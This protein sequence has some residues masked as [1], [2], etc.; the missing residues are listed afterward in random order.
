LDIAISIKELSKVYTTPFGGHS[1]KAL[2]NFNLD[3]RC[4]ETLAVIGPNGSGKTT[5]LKLLLGLIYPTSGSAYILGKSIASVDAREHVGYLPEEAYFYDCFSG[6][7]LLDYYGKLFG[8]STKVRR[9]RV[10]ELLALVGLSER[11]ALPL[12]AYSKGMRQRAGLAQALINDPEVLILD[13]PTSGLDPEGA[14]QMRRLI[15]ELRQRGKTILLCSHFLSQVEDLCDRV[16]ILDRGQLKRCGPLSELV[17]DSTHIRIVAELSDGAVLME[18]R[19]LCNQVEEQEGRVVLE[20]N[21]EAVAMEILDLL[22]ARQCR[23][24]EMLR[25]RLTLEELFIRVMQEGK[26]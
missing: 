22:R 9:Q 7:E 4:G 20:T 12:R 18:L 17:G 26:A 8:L 2:D 11:S 24:V 14:Y 25:P 3:I 23:L 5:T 1:V 13:E 16:A 15:R 6:E 21:K 10:K 19:K